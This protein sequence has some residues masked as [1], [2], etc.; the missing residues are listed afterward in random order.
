MVSFSSIVFFSIVSTLIDVSTF[1]TLEET[2]PL[3]KQL[4]YIVE[5]ISN[6]DLDTNAKLL[7]WSEKKFQNKVNEKIS[8]DIALTQVALATKVEDMKKVLEN[9]F[10]LY[11]KLCNPSLFTQGTR[12]Y[13][14]SLGSQISISG[15]RLP[16]NPAQSEKHFRTFLHT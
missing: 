15:A 1:P 8:S 3:M 9:I 7:E 4:T 5:N 16:T 14:L 13:I 10:S 12:S 2:K 6:E 11:T